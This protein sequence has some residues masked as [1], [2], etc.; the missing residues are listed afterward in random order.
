MSNT[1]PLLVISG[2]MGAGKTTALSEASDLLANTGIP[3][4]A[5]DL[6]WLG[7]MHP[8]RGPHGEPLV[9]AN[10]AAI[11]PQYRSAGAGRLIVARVVENR[12]ELQRYEEA[13][14]GAQ[15]VVCR[16]T[17]SLKT[18]RDRLRVREPG[19]F[20]ARALDRSAELESM[21]TK[22]G[23]EDFVVD[24]DAGRLIGDVARDV[25]TGAGWL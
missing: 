8:P 1:V 14:P 18:M 25:L 5:I 6:D 7:V 3:H 2:S 17:A 13:V 10:L 20:Q 22:S 19:L 23:S 9:F 16:L 24:N 4:A 21:L 12:S 11:W 15:V